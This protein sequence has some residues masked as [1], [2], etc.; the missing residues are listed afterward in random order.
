M[1]V[2]NRMFKSVVKWRWS[3][4]TSTSDFR[5]QHPTSTSYLD[6]KLFWNSFLS[7]FDYSVF[8][9][10]MLSPMFVMLICWP[11]IIIV[12]A[13][14]GINRRQR[15]LM[16]AIIGAGLYYHRSRVQKR[17]RKQ[18]VDPYFL[19]RLIS[20]TFHHAM[21][22][23]KRDPVKFYSYLRMDLERFNMLLGLVKPMYLFLF[24]WWFIFVLLLTN[25][26]SVEGLRSRLY[27]PQ[28]AQRKDYLS[29]SVISLMDTVT[30]VWKWTS[31]FLITLFLW[32]LKKPA[33]LFI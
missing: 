30:E 6:K 13:K 16:I 28:L 15:F 23:L 33:Q 8:C 18:W 5:L 17:P 20:G 27:A 19:K 32:S 25:Y 24:N 21:R 22:D 1:E 4:W 14:M 11:H 31:E 3:Q 26:Y 10:S 2:G 9:L 12:L 7:T 29:R